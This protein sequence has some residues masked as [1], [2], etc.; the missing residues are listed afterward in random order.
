VVAEVLEMSMIGDCAIG[1]DGQI[2]IAVTPFSAVARLS[3]D[4]GYSW[5]NL[6]LPSGVL[7]CSCAIGPDNLTVL[8]GCTSGILLLSSDLGENWEEMPGPAEGNWGGNVFGVGIADDNQTMVLCVAGGRCW[9]TVNRWLTQYEIR[10]NEDADKEWSRIGISGNGLVLLASEYGGRLFLSINGG[11]TPGWPETRPDGDKD[12]GWACVAVGRDNK[13]LFAGQ[14]GGGLFRSFDVGVKWQQEI[15]G[16]WAN[17]DWTSVSLGGSELWSVISRY[18]SS[19]DNE[20]FFGT[21]TA[22]AP[23]PTP[24]GPIVFPIVDK[25]SLVAH[26]SRLTV[27]KVEIVGLPVETDFLG[28]NE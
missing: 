23:P 25:L 9:K 13:S 3:Y 12:L 1:P 19:T 15:V 10:P 27:D 21:F 4:A 17:A 5:Q 7:A 28:I 18:A 22:P 6:A 8:L 2:A 20:V 16:G 11:E 26:R 24:P 14:I